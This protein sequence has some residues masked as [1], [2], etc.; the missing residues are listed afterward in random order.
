MHVLMHIL[1]CHG[2]ADGLVEN[3]LVDSH[4]GIGSLRHANGRLLECCWSW[5]LSQ[6]EGG[7]G[8]VVD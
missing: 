3:V 8:V 5:R 6:E 7:R 2:L 4:V 1:L